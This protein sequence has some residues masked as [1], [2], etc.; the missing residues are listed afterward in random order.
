MFESSLLESSYGTRHSRS[1][2]SKGLS[3]AVEFLLLALA[4]L[5]PLLYTEAL[6]RQVLN[7]VELPTPPDAAPAPR[8]SSVVSHPTTRSELNNGR[9]M[10]PSTIPRRVQ[11]IHDEPAGDSNLNGSSDGVG[12]APPNGSPTGVIASLFRAA[13]QPM[14]K[15]MPLS[16]VR[17]SSGVAEGLLIRQVRPQYPALARSARI[18]GTVILQAMI[19]KDGSIEKVRLLSGHPLLVQA[20]V[21]AVRQWRYRP[22]LL[23][24]EPVEVDTTIQVNFTLGGA[25]N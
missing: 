4:I 24:N 2:W 13:P 12:G 14:A 16:A 1:T 5:A 9:I 22:Y 3:F 15:T 19:G 7:I 20:A 10:L 25:S 23:N 11:E 6:P 18:Q 8:T 21:E 17:V